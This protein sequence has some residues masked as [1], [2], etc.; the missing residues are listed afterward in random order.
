MNVF[1]LGG[2]ACAGKTTIARHLAATYSLTLYSCDDHFEEHRLRADPARHPHFSRLMDAPMEE[3]LARPESAQA[4]E[5]LRFYQDELDMVL[6]DLRRL[7]GPVLVEGV[8]L[9]PERIAA[10][11]PDPHR[12]LW[13]IAT[14]E[15]RR[16]AY[17]RRGPLVR[18]VLSRCA[19]PEEAFIRWMERDDRI[20]R[21]LASG[22]RR[23]GLSVLKVN[24]RKT[25]EEMAGI[26]AERLR[27]ATTDSPSPGRA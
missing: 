4:A 14:P 27:L 12:A 17:L 8:G 16:Q 6:E 7:S 26:V 25:V 13:L 10:V 18:K 22:A 21:R 3:L 15:F 24:G 20:A 2:S 1:W 9:L 19:E 11:G 23:C 5:L